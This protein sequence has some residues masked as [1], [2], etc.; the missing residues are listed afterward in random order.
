MNYICILDFVFGNPRTE[1]KIW[2]LP[3]T[4]GQ[5]GSNNLSF[6]ILF[7]DFDTELLYKYEVL[8]STTVKVRQ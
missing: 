2:H 3:P 5:L 8:N 1:K 4:N 7:L 6:D